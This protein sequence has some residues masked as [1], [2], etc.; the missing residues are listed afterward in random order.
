MAD[1]RRVGLRHVGGLC[2]SVEIR[3]Q[4]HVDFTDR[5]NGAGLDELHGAP[6][7]APLVNLCSHLRHE[8]VLARDRSHHPCLVHAVRQRLLAVAV[9]AQLHG[10]HA[11]RRVRVIRR[12]DHDCIDLCMHFVQ[13]PAEVLVAFGLRELLEVLRGPCFVHVAQGDEVLVCQ[14]FTS[15][16]PRPP[17]PIAAMFSFS[18]GELDCPN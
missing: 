2:G 15:S 3:A 4:P 1:L 7:V 17:T 6:V 16:P 13:H 18:L 5:A 8:L 14:P 10:H 11:G 12:A 9:L